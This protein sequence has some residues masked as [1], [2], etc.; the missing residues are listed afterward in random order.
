MKVKFITVFGEA[1]SG[2]NL[3]I[4]GLDITYWGWWQWYKWR[5]HGTHID[6]GIFSIYNLSQTG[7]RYFLWR[8]LSIL[9]KPMRLFY[10]KIWLPHSRAKKLSKYH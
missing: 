1:I 7:I 6:C 4:F 5:W 9:I 3:K 2:R 10:H 8:V